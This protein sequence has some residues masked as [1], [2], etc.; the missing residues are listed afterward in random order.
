MLTITIPAHGI[1]EISHLVLDFNGTI[2]TDG[3]LLL[4]VADRLRRLSEN[5]QIYVLTA[6][7]NG[8]AQRECQDIPVSVQIIGRQDQ[9]GEKKRFVEGLAGHAAVVGNGRNDLQMFGYAALA[10]AVIGDEGCSTQTMMNSDVI[11]KQINDALDLLLNPNRLI[12]TL[13]N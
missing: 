8:S 4:G 13:R 10:I 9:E 6:D 5:L 3:R 11:V 2:A 12:A 7:T 1:L